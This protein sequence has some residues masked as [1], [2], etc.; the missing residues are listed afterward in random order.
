MVK[1]RCQ[2]TSRDSFKSENG[3][4]CMSFYNL[5]FHDVVPRDSRIFEDCRYSHSIN[6]YYELILFVSVK[7]VFMYA[8]NIYFEL[9]E[10]LNL[11]S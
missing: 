10:I 11:L 9:I 7:R 4:N 2:C 6:L 3:C 1:K 8:N 5:Q